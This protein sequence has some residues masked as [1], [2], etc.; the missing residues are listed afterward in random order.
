VPFSEYFFALSR[1]GEAWRRCGFMFQAEVG[2]MGRVWEQAD[3]PTADRLVWS[4]I[5]M[6][7]WR[8]SKGGEAHGNEAGLETRSVP[9]PHLTVARGLVFFLLKEI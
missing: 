8:R 5:S 3:P 2:R 6:K 7:P 1:F 4:R 9:F